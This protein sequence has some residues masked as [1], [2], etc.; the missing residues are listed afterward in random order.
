M[1]CHAV[2]AVCITLSIV[3]L[4]FDF[5]SLAW[6]V[7]AQHMTAPVNTGGRTNCFAMHA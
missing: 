5:L 3:T 4:G 1:L 7:P 6:D 2:F